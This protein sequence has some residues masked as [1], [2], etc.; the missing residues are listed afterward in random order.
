M[1]MTRWWR[2]VQSSLPPEVINL[3][4]LLKEHGF[5]GYLVGGAPR[6]LLL[7]KVPKDW[8]L[9]TDALPETVEEICMEHDQEETK[10]IQ[11]GKKF[12]TIKLLRNGLVIE[13]T[14]FRREGPYSDGRHP[15]WVEFRPGIEEDLSRR[16]FTVNAMALDVLGNQLIDPFGGRRDLK[17]KVIRA[18]GDPEQRFAEDALRMLR[19]FR[20]QSGLGFRGD[21]TTERAINPY[22][23]KQISPERIREEL[24]KLLVSP[25]PERGLLGLIRT[26][27]LLSVAPEFTSVV[28]DE[29]LTAHLLKT[30][31]TIKPHPHLRWA[32]LLHDLGK[33]QC[34]TVDENGL[35]YYGHA[36]VGEE[37]AHGL[38]ER[39][40]F[41]K[42]FIKRVTILIRWHMFSADPGQTDAALRRL[43]LKVGEENLGGLLE[44]RRA[45]IIA[46]GQNYHRAWEG[47]SAFASRVE[48]L[49]QK[50]KVLTLQDL[51]VNGEDIMKTLGIPAGPQVG[52]VLQDLFAWVTEEPDRNNEK[53]LYCYLEEHYQTANRQINSKD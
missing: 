40:R 1:F 41:S 8:D 27:L 39:L 53:D 42:D 36:E 28:T 15:D 16:D 2:F 10:V 7:S 6:D 24:T 13:V 18:V 45:D 29:H 43:A 49:L 25:R 3:I 47:F 33:T 4:K 52:V 5:T 46:S 48:A 12:G 51:A 21:R 44:L 30:V 37:L 38:L 34:R 23:V 20:F 22:L 50:E 31:E 35:H 17:Q 26:G 32:A 14:T 9:A 11:V 19:F